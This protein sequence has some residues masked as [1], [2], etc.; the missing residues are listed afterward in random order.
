MDD[1][2]NP[3]KRE[4]VLICLHADQFVEVFAEKH[5]DVKI[6]SVPDCPGSE[7]LAEDTLELMLPQRW[8][9]LYWPAKVR[10]VAMHRP[11]KPSTVMDAI[12]VQRL[13]REI[14]GAA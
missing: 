13:V 6:V 4:Q 5:I 1:N 7:A 11:L 10:A 9:R 2:K 3:P 8:R 14:G 12:C